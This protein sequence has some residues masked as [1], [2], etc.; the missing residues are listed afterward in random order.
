MM[1]GPVAPFL[2]VVG[3][4]VIVP[5]EWKMSYLT[6]QAGLGGGCYQICGK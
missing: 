6:L 5:V 4:D 2:A 3:W 1:I